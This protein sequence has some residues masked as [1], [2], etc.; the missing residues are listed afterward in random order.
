M[1]RRGSWVRASLVTVLGVAA[2]T[3]AIALA[4]GEKFR[5]RPP[6]MTRAS[7][8]VYVLQWSDRLPGTLDSGLRSVT[9]YFATRPDGSDRKR[10]TT[11]FA[12]R[13]GPEFVERWRGEG[14]VTAD[15]VVRRDGRQ[16]LSL[17]SGV[18]TARAV[19]VERLPKDVVVS[20]L[21]RPR[22]LKTG[23]SIALRVRPNGNGY[24][25][26]VDERGLRLG[27]GTRDMAFR[28]ADRLVANNWYWFEVGLRT[29]KEEV[30]ARV[31]VYDENRTRLIA[32][33]EYF[34]RPRDP[35]LFGGGA[36]ALAGPADF[37]ELYV[38]PWHAC[39]IDASENELAWDTRDVPDGDYYIIAEVADGKR[40]PLRVV[41][42]YQISVRRA[43][44]AGMALREN[45]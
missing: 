35:E 6:T 25:L 26:R 43:A 10:I 18:L 23:F 7:N 36:M 19:S 21:V 27:D 37:A 17:P 4:Q 20:A 13:F 42:K 34:D 39:W 30:I 15:S 41:S 45:P 29:R 33:L 24:L 44:G 28:G 1:V 8:A 12:E 3:P 5:L 11:L 32:G 9:W 31:R 2:I 40:P 22:D 14:G 38:D 16:F